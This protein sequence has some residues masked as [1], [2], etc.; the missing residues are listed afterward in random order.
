MRTLIFAPVTFNLAETTRMIVI[1]R[2][3]GPEWRAI[4][5]VYEDPYTHLIRDAGFEVRRLAPVL[6]PDQQAQALAL[7]QGRS[8]RHPFSTRLVRARVTAERRLIRQTGAEAV[9]MGTN[10]T[11]L[12]SARA[13]AVPLFYAVPFALTRP[14]VEQTARLGLV[15]ASGPLPGALAAVSGAVSGA[16]DAVSDAVSSA[17]RGALDAAGS[18]AFRLVYDRLPIAPRAFTAVAREVGVPPL[19]TGAALFEGD[20]NLLTVMGSELAGYSL[21]AGYRRVGPIFAELPGEVPPVVRELAAGPR[22]LVY[23]A[24]GSSGDRRTVLA[25]VASLAHLDVEVVAPVRH[26]LEPG[27]ESELPERVHLVDLLPAHRLGGLVDAAVIHGGQGTVQTACATGVPFVGMGMQP[28]QSWNIAVCAREG[29]AIALPR[30]AAGT[31]RLTE[32][33]RALLTDPRYRQAAD[34]VQAEFAAEDGAA[35][36]VAAIEEVLGAAG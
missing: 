8:I 28:E 21:P 36:A 33:V 22:P 32:A 35:A 23:L 12:I 25:A 30:R 31:R 15:P 18:A 11:S 2:A 3:L 34:R 14:H 26:L 9:V 16:L 7:D 5:Q 10:V 6:T 17:V 1:A 19:R 4:F 27:D 13:E 24:L 20:I 29:N